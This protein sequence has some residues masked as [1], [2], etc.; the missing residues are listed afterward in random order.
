MRQLR[1]ALNRQEIADRSRRIVE[2]LL[3]MEEVQSAASL[4]IYLSFRS[5]VET[6]S[7][8]EILIADGKKV[9]VPSVGDSENMEAVQFTPQEQLEGDKFGVPTP[10]SGVIEKDLVD[11]CIAPGLAF[12]PV[13]DRLGY[14]KGYYDR[15][16]ARRQ[17]GLAIGLCFECQ[18]F[19]QV[20]VDQF[21]HPMD[22]VLT[23][24]R[25]FQTCRSTDR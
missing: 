2:R 16:F 3:G 25:S 13:G 18:I 1:N 8:I 17:V 21:D 7:L 19:S 14:G 20:P 10:R 12:S 5:E 24:E 22:W 6:R 11:V 23:E 15:F 9:L 4:F